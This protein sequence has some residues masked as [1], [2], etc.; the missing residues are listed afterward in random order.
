[1][2]QIILL[3]HHHKKP[4]SVDLSFHKYRKTD[5]LVIINLGREFTDLLRIHILLHNLEGVAPPMYLCFISEG[6]DGFTFHWCGSSHPK[7]TVRYSCF[8]ALSSPTMIFSILHPSRVE[9]FEK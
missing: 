8:R 3:S 4:D 1:M 5:F 9:I 2:S 6:P 7:L